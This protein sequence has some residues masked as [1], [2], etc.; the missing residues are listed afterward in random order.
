L[1]G[2]GKFM[3]H[4]KIRPGSILYAAALAQLIAAAHADMQER[5]EEERSRKR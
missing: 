5:V 4:V 2:T 3:R 1:E